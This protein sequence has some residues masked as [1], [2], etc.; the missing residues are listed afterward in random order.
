MEA[1]FTKAAQDTKGQS[2]QEKQSYLMLILSRQQESMQEELV[3]AT[4]LKEEVFVG[5]LHKFGNGGEDSRC[6]KIL[7]SMQEKLEEYRN[8]YFSA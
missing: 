6:M 1:L 2:L 5:C 3:A 4:G 7:M 8:K